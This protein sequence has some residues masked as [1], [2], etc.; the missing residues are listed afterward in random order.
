MQYRTVKGAPAGVGGPWVES[1]RS[2]FR[3]YL[4][5]WGSTPW[6]RT[7]PHKASIFTTKAHMSINPKVLWVP[8]G[9][10]SSTLTIHGT[11]LDGPGSFT[12]HYPATD[13]GQ[14][15]SFVTVPTS[16]CWRVA[17]RSG[18]LHGSVTFL[19]TDKP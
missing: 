10:S 13:G 7:R 16:G 15:P 14:V 11:R 4:F 1:T 19:A 12:A 17:L 5:Y 8:L 6:A 2:A 18:S 9:R 3:G